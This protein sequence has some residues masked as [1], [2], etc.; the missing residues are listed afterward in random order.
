MSLVSNQ[1]SRIYLKIW[2]RWEWECERSKENEEGWD[3][4]SQRFFIRLLEEGAVGLDV[5]G[6]FPDLRCCSS[7]TLCSMA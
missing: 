4:P 7:F 6:L 2:N 1:G 5:E 3:L